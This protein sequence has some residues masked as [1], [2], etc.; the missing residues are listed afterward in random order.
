MT[1][2]TGCLVTDQI[3]LPAVPVSPPVVSLRDYDNPASLIVF[4]RDIGKLNELTVALQIRDEDTIEPLRARWRVVTKERPPGAPIKDYPCPEPEVPDTGSV[5][6]SYPLTIP[7]SSFPRGK[8]SRVDF[9]VSGS[10]KMCKPDRDDGWDITTQE[11]DAAD[12]GRL[13]FWVWDTSGTDILSAAQTLVASCP[14]V[15]YRPPS[16]TASTASATSGGP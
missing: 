13:S 4:N 6:R 14:T 7:A 10:F 15:D 16:A 5:L 2:W 12:I 3:E 11:D 8:C 1:G 9:I